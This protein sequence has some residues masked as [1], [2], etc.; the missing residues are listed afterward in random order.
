MVG[1]DYKITWIIFGRGAG[2]E[3]VC[4]SVLLTVMYTLLVIQT[5]T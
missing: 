4:I 2:E 3:I 5:L 1:R